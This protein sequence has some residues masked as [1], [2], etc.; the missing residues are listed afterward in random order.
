MES[1]YFSLLEL[2]D[3]MYENLEVNIS[4]IVIL[5]CAIL[6]ASIGLNMNSTPVIIGAMLISP[7]MNS[8]LGM[9]IGLSIYDMNL[10]KRSLK[11]M[12][13]QVGVSLLTSFVYF[14]ISPISYASTEIIARTTPTI[15]DVII[16]FVGGVAGI[17]SARQK[18]TSNIVPG[19]AIATALMPP[20]CTAGYGLA[21]GNFRY[22]FGAS[23]LFLINTCFIM[24][25]TFIGIRLMYKIY[26]KIDVNKKIKNTLIAISFLII[27]P[28]LFSAGK[29]V[30]QTVRKDA[31]EKM[32]SREFSDHVIIKK[33]YL[34]EDNMVELTIAG[35]ILSNSKI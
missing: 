26:G 15:W 34:F 6:I 3:K 33:R 19:V 2:K 35:E 17:I 10:V 29:L 27:I 8:I 1:R 14:L 11:L 24:I 25:A 7:L 30:T 28:S 9:G 31:V 20:V 23:Y 5:M 18:E 4:K 12:M 21:K 22:F 16:A 13:V 32:I